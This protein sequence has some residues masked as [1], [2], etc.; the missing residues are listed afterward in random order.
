MEIQVKKQ[1]VNYS[2]QYVLMA[3]K[4]SCGLKIDI[5]ILMILCKAYVAC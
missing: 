1:A 2:T 3:G 5:K 4:V